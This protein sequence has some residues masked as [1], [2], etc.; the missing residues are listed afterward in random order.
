MLTIEVSV[1]HHTRSSGFVI[2]LF[3]YV[4]EVRDANQ[5]VELITN[6]NCSQG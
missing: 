3:A 4:D 6:L 1:C 5:Q 2:L